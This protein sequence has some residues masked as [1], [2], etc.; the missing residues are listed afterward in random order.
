ML[1]PK[2]LKLIKK[3]LEEDIPSS[4]TIKQEHFNGEHPLPITDSEL[5]HVKDGD[6]YVT[7]SLNKKKLQHIRDD[8]SGGF[9][10]LL[11]LLPAI[12][13]GLGALGGIAGGAASIA[14]SVNKKKNEDE[15][16][17]EERRHN[18]ELESKLG[19][20]MNSVKIGKTNCPHCGGMLI[21]KGKKGRGLYLSPYS[22]SGSGLIR[23]IGDLAHNPAT[24]GQPLPDIPDSIKQIPLLGSLAS[25]IY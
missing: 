25:L 20:G 16:L 23:A 1:T 11:T 7:V 3:S 17:E 10:P 14:S 4:L 13:G 19:S 24:N 12:L 15:R 8:K 9:L 2:Q 6:G 22:S 21:L 5:K 18:R